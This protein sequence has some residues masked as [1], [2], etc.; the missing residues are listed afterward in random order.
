MSFLPINPR[1]FLQD[2]VNKSIWVRLKWGESEY[3]GTLVSIDSYMNLQLSN[4]EEYI[5]HK[6][7]GSLGQILIRSNN[8]LWIRSA[9]GTENGGDTKMEG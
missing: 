4:A 6:F 9:D 8:V 5:S 3:K 1:P 7:S 2:L